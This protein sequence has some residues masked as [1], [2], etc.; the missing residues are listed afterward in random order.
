LGNGPHDLAVLRRMAINAMQKDAEKGSLRGEIK[1]AGWDDA[2]SR[3][4]SPC[5]EM[6]SPWPGRSAVLTATIL[7]D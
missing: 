6:R 2:T 3:G 4:C 1:R 5:F 7:R